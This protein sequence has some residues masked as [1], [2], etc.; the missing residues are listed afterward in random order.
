MIGKIATRVLQ[1]RPYSEIEP[2]IAPLVTAMNLHRVSETTASCEGHL[3]GRAPYVYF[4]CHPILAARMEKCL[5]EPGESPDGVL[6]F[7]WQITGTFNES[8]E[9]TY[10]LRSCQL[11]RA[12]NSVFWLLGCYLHRARM[13]LSVLAPL[14]GNII[15]RYCFEIEYQK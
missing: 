14:M 11:D 12:S 9:P 7:S 6:H 8:Y 15:D 4:A 2:R 1:R 10:L 5:R 13:D 3:S